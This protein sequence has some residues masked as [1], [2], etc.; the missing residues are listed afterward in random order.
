MSDVLLSDFAS[1]N[2]DL[3]AFF[4]SH[5][6]PF[7]AYEFLDRGMLRLGACMSNSS[8]QANSFLE[9]ARKKPICDI[10]R[11]L[12]KKRTYTG[13][14]WVSFRGED[15][16]VTR[17]NENSRRRIDSKA[18]HGRGSRSAVGYSLRLRKLGIKF[19]FNDLR[20]VALYILD[21]SKTS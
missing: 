8:E 21:K 5:S 17:R 1:R 9:S 18:R 10:V 2:S 19:N 7:C 16:N 12:I 20:A 13:I 11:Q 15:S 3:A 6:Q 14:N 4:R